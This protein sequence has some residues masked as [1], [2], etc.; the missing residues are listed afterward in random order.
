[1]DIAEKDVP[2]HERI[3]VVDDEP[4]VRRF[5]CR[6]LEDAGYRIA[7]AADG[8]EALQA[9]RERSAKFDAVV[10]DIVMPRLNGV[11]LLQA[12]SVSHPELPIILMSGY[13]TADLAERGIAAPCSVLNKPFAPERL[14]AEVRRCL[15]RSSPETPTRSTA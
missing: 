15:D 6:V 8:A 12:L 2:G 5:A 13:A 9:V 10:S 4:V 1:V 11:E 3:L 14:L 7:A